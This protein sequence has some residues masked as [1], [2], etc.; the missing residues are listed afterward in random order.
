MSQRTGASSTTKDSLILGAGILSIKATSGGSFVKIG[1][2]RGGGS[3][4]S[5]IPLRDIEADGLQGAT[6]GM[7]VKDKGNPTLAVTILEVNKTILSQVM[8][9]TQLNGNVITSDGQ[10]KDTDYLYEVQWVGYRPGSTDLVK[11]TIQNALVK[12]TIALAFAD[13]DEA[14]IPLTFMGHY[15]LDAVETDDGFLP[16]PWSIESVN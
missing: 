13:N 12:E 10:I 7:T 6:K 16:E 9:G 1:A 4:D 8:P 15:D 14:T 11:I 2:T 3:F 5:G